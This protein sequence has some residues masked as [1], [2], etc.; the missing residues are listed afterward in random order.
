MGGGGLKTPFL[1]NF[2]KRGGGGGGMGEGGGGVAPSPPR[3]L[4]FKMTEFLS[5]F[6]CRY[7]VSFRPRVLPRHR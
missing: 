5:M 2:Q 7:L 3:D 1:S 4:Y 6:E